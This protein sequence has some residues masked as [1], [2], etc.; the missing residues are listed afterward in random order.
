MMK[1][2]ETDHRRASQISRLIFTAGVVLLVPGTS[3]T[4]Q[5][6]SLGNDD[7]VRSSS[8]TVTDEKSDK[9]KMQG[10]WK[11]VRCEF[12]GQNQDQPVGVEDTISGDRWLRPKRRTAEYRLKFD[13]SK[14]PKWVDLSADRLGD[15]TLKGIYLLEGDKLTICYAYDPEL[16]RPTEFKTMAGVNSYIYVLELV[17]KD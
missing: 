5:T 10:E 15:Q 14:D 16:P 13:T 4:L 6:R 7:G 3:L 12:H 8:A 9:E 1:Y 2:S 11:I 17:K